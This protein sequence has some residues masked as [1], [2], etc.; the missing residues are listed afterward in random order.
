MCQHVV[1]RWKCHSTCFLYFSTQIK[2]HVIINCK[3]M[4]FSGMHIY[5]CNYL[6]ISIN[7]YQIKVKSWGEDNSL[8]SWGKSKTLVFVLLWNNEKTLVK[9]PNEWKQSLHTEWGFLNWSVPKGRNPEL[10]WEKLV[11]R[12]LTPIWPELFICIVI[13][14]FVINHLNLNKKKI[15]MLGSPKK[16]LKQTENY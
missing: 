14:I 12:L 7:L 5:L 9:S 13:L 2:S 16:N 6:S 10:A 11:L 1:E 4:L 8:Y 15:E 3:M